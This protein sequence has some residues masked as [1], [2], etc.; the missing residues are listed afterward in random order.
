MSDVLAEAPWRKP[1]PETASVVLRERKLQIPQSRRPELPPLS[2]YHEPWW[3]DIA[4][5]G[6]WDEAKVFDNGTLIARMPY[7]IERRLGLRI[8]RLP[9]LIRTLGPAMIDMPG[10]P[11]AALRRR[12]EITNQLIDQL[13]AFDQF[14]Q[15]FD[16]RITDAVSFAYRGF[17]TGTTYA[18]QI[19]TRSPEE[20]I[21]AAMNDKTRNVIR[22]VKDRLS[23]RIMDD[24]GL[25]VAFYTSNLE[26]Q[27]NFHGCTRLTRLLEAILSQNAG[28]LLGAFDEADQPVAAACITWDAVSAY[29]FLSTRR[30]DAPSG[31]TSLLIW[32]AARI[33]CR[34]Q[35]AFDLDG[36][37]SPQSLLFLSGFG[38][39]MVQRLRVRRSSKL[40]RVANLSLSAI[41]GQI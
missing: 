14:D 7:S 11:A 22:K 9:T 38:G 39:R 8:S 10:K 16:P 19:D 40:F 15:L 5:D 1:R 31:A 32:E 28:T 6:N 26:K 36:V 27:A 25:F 13:P 33:A 30:P 18:F 4:A 17:V 37:T 29:H 41:G 3:L 23:V 24:P 12:L 34:R 2:I 20:Q 35:L 21:W